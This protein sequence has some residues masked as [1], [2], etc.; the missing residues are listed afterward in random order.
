MEQSITEKN[1]VLLVDDDENI[2]AAL[3]RLL[4][5]EPYSVLTA[6]SGE[7]A[8]GILNKRKVDLI[9]C[10]YTMPGP[11]ASETFKLIQK[12]WPEI[13]RILI[14]GHYD[15]ET[16]TQAVVSGEA[17]RYMQKP[18]NDDDMIVTIRQSLE[19]ARLQNEVRHLTE[20]L[21]RCRPKA[22]NPQTA[23]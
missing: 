12:R 17:Y 6:S 21:E 13:I 23:K 11:T 15:S 5:N 19:I 22:T 16:L 18:W 1:T 14:T 9:V 8:I 7:E 4:R 2:L 3:K 10:D 20:E